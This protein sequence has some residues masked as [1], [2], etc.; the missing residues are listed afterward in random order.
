MGFIQFN[1][2]Q[3]NSV[4]L[5]FNNPKGKF[6]CFLTYIILVYLKSYYTGGYEQEESPVVVLLTDDLTKPPIEDT[7]VV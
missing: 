1:S 3:F 6:K 5:Y 7:V 2:I 4:Q